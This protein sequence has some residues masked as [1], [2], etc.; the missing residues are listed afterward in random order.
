M[1]KSIFVDREAELAR[2]EAFWQQVHSGIGSILLVEGPAGIGKS[3]LIRF[4]VESD[5]SRYL[6]VVR[7]ATRVITTF[8]HSQVGPENA[9]GPFFDLLVQ[10]YT[11]RNK[12][13]LRATS[14]V[15]A[16][17]GPA[18][19]EL[20]PGI[21]KVLSSGA[22]AAREALSSVP[23]ERYNLQTVARMVSQEVLRVL[24]KRPSILVIEDAHLLDASS[25]AVLR[26]LCQTMSERQFGIVLTCRSDEL[27]RN[28][29]ALDLMDRLHSSGGLDRLVLNGLP[30]PA[31]VE[32]FVLRT[33]KRPS[34]SYLEE[35]AQRSGGHPLSLDYY[36]SDCSPSDLPTEGSLLTRA[37]SVIRSRLR[38]LDPDEY[39]LLK[40]AA[41]Q[42]ERFLSSVVRD[43]L[44]RPDDEV[45][46]PLHRIAEATGLIKELD[47]LPWIEAVDSDWYAFT[48]NCLEMCCAKIRVGKSDAIATGRS[49]RL[50]SVWWRRPRARREMSSWRLSASTT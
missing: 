30:K 29:A 17:A 34:A 24:D 42:G 43:V 45:L 14:R 12:R 38:C 8:C 22:V 26:C 50:C 44:G 20:V 21:G 15:T 1:P 6:T 48:M 7:R 4:F 37:E 39:L 2:L 41:I 35:L 13:W 10:L 3:S 9:Y 32:Y 18:L 23:G 49:L 47:P 25:C 27:R 31:I 16:E 28:D 46:G 40:V 11:A 33:G 19:L 36:F 5:G